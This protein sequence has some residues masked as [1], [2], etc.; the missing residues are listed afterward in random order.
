MAVERLRTSDRSEHNTYQYL[1]V[2]MVGAL[3]TLAVSMLIEL[4]QND[5]C[6]QTSISAYYFTEVQAVFVGTLLVLGVAMIVISGRLVV[7]DAALNVAGLL[8]PIVAFAPTKELDY[9]GL[10]AAETR[11]KKAE[12]AAAFSNGS[13]DNNMVAY[14]VV[15]AVGL[16]VAGLVLRSTKSR[17]AYWTAW[18]LS[19]AWLLLVAFTFFWRNEDFD[20]KAHLVSAVTMFVFIFVVVCANAADQAARDAKSNGADFDGWPD[21]LRRAG[22]TRYGLIA[23]AMIVG[24]VGIAAWKLAFGFDHWFFWIE[25]VL[26]VLF[27]LFWVT[28]T[29]DRLRK[30]D[31]T[32]DRGE[33]PASPLHQQP[34]PQT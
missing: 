11:D 30:P 17:G 20:D 26:I 6:A 32:H 2:G 33:Q 3:L 4:G 18:G 13:V 7:E 29:L 27:A 16:L 28:Q 9:C 31:H 14:L 21:R 12:V 8:A 10:N 22:S 23:M 5:W 19:A 34:Q 1:R 25:V 24:V 15:V